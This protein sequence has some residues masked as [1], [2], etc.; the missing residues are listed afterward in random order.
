VKE[1]TDKDGNSRLR[2]GSFAN[3]PTSLAHSIFAENVPAAGLSPAMVDMN[4]KIVVGPVSEMLVVRRVQGDVIA[5]HE[6]FRQLRGML[7][8]ETY[9]A[10]STDAVKSMSNADLGHHV[11][12]LRASS[13]ASNMATPREPK[14]Q[15]LFKE[16]SMLM[17]GYYGLAMRMINGL[18]LKSRW[19]H[20]RK[21]SKTFSGNDAMLWMMDSGVADTEEEATEMG[22]AML[23]S[24]YYHEIRHSKGFSC[25]PKVYF[26]WADP[27]PGAMAGPTPVRASSVRENSIM[28]HPAFKSIF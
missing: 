11:K 7:S 19:Y 16:E 9:G 24:G 13:I 2:S 17:E 15:A 25:S 8:Q 22:A 4:F 18:P 23:L 3:T 28:E 21:Y 20:L 12:R 10:L 1:N 6:I 5:Y 14:R 27:L 26:Q